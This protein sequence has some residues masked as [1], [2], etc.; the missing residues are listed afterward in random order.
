[1][2]QVIIFLFFIITCPGLVTAQKTD[3]S[4]LRKITLLPVVSKT[5]LVQNDTSTP[6]YLTGNQFLNK[7][8]TVASRVI[9]YK[10]RKKNEATFYL[11]AGLVFMLA[12]FRFFFTRYFNNLFKVFF[13]TSFR[14]SQ[15]T[16]QLL[17]AKL[18]SLLLNLF[19]IIC[20][21]IYFYSLLSYYHLITG[22]NKWILMALSI[23]ILGLIY[24][25]KYGILKF[26]GG[27]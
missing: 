27:K 6:A 23:G 1:M 3:T 9:Q 4:I 14:Q 25:V 21:G 11:L 16:D 2:K 13:N 19:F 12:F 18:P 26:T 5:I 22:Q 8:G 24:F 7:R 20:G 17:Q 15:L 10:M